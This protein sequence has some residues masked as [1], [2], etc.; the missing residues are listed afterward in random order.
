MRPN[1]LLRA[2]L[3]LGLSY[4]THECTASPVAFHFALTEREL[5]PTSIDPSCHD[6]IVGQHRT[7]TQV[8]LAINEG[9]LI[10]SYNPATGYTY[11]KV[12][13]FIGTTVPDRK[14]GLYAY[15]TDKGFCT[16]SPDGT[17]ATCKIPLTKLNSADQLCSGIEYNLATHAELVSTSGGDTETG[18]GDGQ[19]IKDDCKPWG[20]YSK[21]KIVCEEPPSPPPPVTCT[22]AGTA[23][24]N[25]PGY[26]AAFSSGSWGWTIQAKVG[27]LSMEAGIRGELYMGAGKSDISKATDVGSVSIKL[28]GDTLA[29]SYVV[30]LESY[31]L[32][33]THV[34]VGESAPAKNAPGSWRFQHENSGTSD[35]S[36]SY[37]FASTSIDSQQMPMSY[38]SDPENIITIV[39]HAEINKCTA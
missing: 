2:T 29:I 35:L 30:D 27:D 21:F 25:I 15:T 36:D 22:E 19:C 32:G 38:L 3:S 20:Y 31:E 37:S 33:T 28:M 34:Y 4:I 23:Y 6:L 18:Y 16:T 1:L 24:G 9:D 39:L 17:S 14:P 11:G 5:V 26:S 7:N 8:C 12:H 13:V 10:V